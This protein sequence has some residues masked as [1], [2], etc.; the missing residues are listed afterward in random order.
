M[1]NYQNGKIYKLVCNITNKIYYGSTTLKLY[2]RK[3]DHVSKYKRFLEKKTHYV[4]SFEII[5]GGDFDIVLIENI[6][7]EDKS[8]LHEREKF[9]IKNNECVNKNIPGRT[10]NEYYQDNKVL[11]HEQKKEY[12]ED[13]K[14]VIKEQIKEYRENN[15]DAIKEYK[16]EYYEAN[17]NAISEHQ[18]EYYEAHKDSIKE[19][20][21][22]YYEKNKNAI[23]DKN[24]VKVPCSYCKNLY[25][26]NA[27]SRHIKLKH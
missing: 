25:N 7:C 6:K 8:Q 27:L 23:S 22:E 24:K 16:K 11:I 13:N 26:K 15:K 14:E 18:K 12:Y 19:Y 21:K 17:K 2:K 5:Q 20:K 3:V 1:P 4:T 9:Y 10:V